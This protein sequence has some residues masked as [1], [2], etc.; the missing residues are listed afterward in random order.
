[1]TERER[2]LAGESYRSRD[3]ELLTLY[4]RAKSLLE[5]YSRTPSTNADDKQRIL[6]ELLGKVGSDV[7]IESPFFCD[8]G[9]NIRLG[10]H[11]F[12]N[13]NC[14]F[15]DSNTITIGSNVLIGPAVQ[16]YTATHPLPPDDRIIAEVPGY[17][18]RALPINI[19]DRAWIGGGAMLMPGVSIGPGST[20]GA[21]SVVTH[22]IPERCFAAGNPCRILR[23]L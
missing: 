11:C 3:P 1:V 13:Y 21:G 19:G 22:D 18:T 15:L 20:I 14:V 4:H 6:T 12:I 23:Q 17:V 10:D 16:L 8:Y 5:K 2:M 7:W 9:S